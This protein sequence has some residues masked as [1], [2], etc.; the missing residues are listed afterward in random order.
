MAQGRKP[1]ANPWDDF[2]RKGKAALKRGNEALANEYFGKAKKAADDAAQM[3]KNKS[4]LVQQWD[5]KLGADFYI[6]RDRAAAKSRGE[7][8][9]AESRNRGF[10]RK[11]RAVGARQQANPSKALEQAGRQKQR[12]V[13]YVKSGGK[14]APQRVAKRAKAKKAASQRVREDISPA[15]RQAASRARMKNKINRARGPR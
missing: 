4:A 9:A 11:V 7:I 13:E 6:Q 2:F 8:A 10:Q 15:Q 14:N 3:N 12:A 1:K 5:R